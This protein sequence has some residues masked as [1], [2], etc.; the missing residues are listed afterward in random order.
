M[1]GHGDIEVA[2]RAMKLGARDFLVKPTPLASIAMIAKELM[3]GEMQI[4]INPE[5]VDRIIGRSSAA[6]VLR[7]TIKRLA[8][9]TSAN[10]SGVL[11]MGPNGSGKALAAIAL[12]ETI[13]AS[14]PLISY[15]CEVASETDLEV[16]FNRASNGTLLL[17][18]VS[19]LS[20]NAQLQLL[21]L[22][23]ENNQRPR[24]IATSSK[25]L[26]PGD[27]FIPDLLY[28]IQVGWVDVPGLSER[29]S[30][31]LPIADHVARSIAHGQ[32]EERPRFTSAARAKLLEHEWPGNIAELANCVE[33]SMLVKASPE[34]DA[35]DIRSI[36]AI[37]FDELPTLLELELSAINKALSRTG[38]NVSR[39]AELLGISRDTLRYRME[40]FELSRP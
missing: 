21:R 6:N 18:R 20:K 4:G 29:T 14:K 19:E 26:T 32:G 8:K 27:T 31:I 10:R 40:K 12:H 16:A 38:G 24:L 30:D 15:D 17:R 3:L 2:V 35:D 36:T 11:I 34:I 13:D 39:A 33:R 23:K 1:T 22:N 7:T 37:P 9:A 25:H 28:L 5:G